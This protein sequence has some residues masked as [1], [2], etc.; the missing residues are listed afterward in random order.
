M[1]HSLSQLATSRNAQRRLPGA[2]K[3]CVAIRV[4]VAA[5]LLSSIWLY[6]AFYVG[7]VHAQSGEI[8]VLR[9]VSPR[10]A[11]R[12]AS[13]VQETGPV[14]VSV[15]AGPDQIVRNGVM[16]MSESLL[17]LQ[18]ASLGNVV[19]GVVPGHLSGLSQAILQPVLGGMASVQA[20]PASSF[21]SVGLAGTRAGLAVLTTP[22]PAVT[23]SATGQIAPSM[24]APLQ[25]LTGGALSSSM[26]P[27]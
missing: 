23:L 15:F 24:Q 6:F 16:A 12:P 25:G 18:D 20:M 13:L 26:V 1:T 21:G 17:L 10:I 19:A 3:E 5:L 22:L 8:I 7:P 11:T 14:K 9:E 2:A 4:F 27:K